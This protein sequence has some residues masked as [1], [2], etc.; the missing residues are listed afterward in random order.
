MRNLGN[1]LMIKVE[2]IVSINAPTSRVWKY[3]TDPQL[4]KKWMGEPEMNIEVITDWVVGDPIVIKAFHHQYF[5][6]YGTVLQFEPEKIIQYTHLSSISHLSDTKESYT[7]ITFKLT[8]KGTQTDLSMSAENF[9]TESI[10]KHMEFYWRVTPV[11][12]KE[13]IE[14]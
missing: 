1:R 5:E 12:L 2:K 7:V 14:K 10:Y 11:L 3:L 13:L 8:S 6:N 9:P 4:M